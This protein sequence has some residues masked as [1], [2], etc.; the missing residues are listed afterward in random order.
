MIGSLDIQYTLQLI[1]PELIK[2]LLILNM[3]L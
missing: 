1:F 2:D 3:I